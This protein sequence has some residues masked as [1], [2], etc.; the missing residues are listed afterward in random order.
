MRH[1]IDQGWPITPGLPSSPAWR[2]FP[3]NCRS[4]ARLAVRFTLDA[5]FTPHRFRL[6]LRRLRKHV[7]L[8]LLSSLHGLRGHATRLAYAWRAAQRLSPPSSTSPGAL[9]SDETDRPSRHAQY[10]PAPYKKRRR[11]PVLRLPLHG[12]L[13]LRIRL[14]R[15]FAP[16]EDSAPLPARRRHRRET[17]YLHTGRLGVSKAAP[18]PQLLQG[19][20]ITVPHRRRY[21]NHG[22]GASLPTF[23]A[24][25][26]LLRAP[27]CCECSPRPP[28]PP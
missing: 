16:A 24:P 17:C 12:G 2:R 7:L 9:R 19:S 28:E 20:P 21:P 27:N 14:S 11:Y 15:R 1:S 25:I 4:E 23:S 22:G 3:H 13:P 18:P 5:L 26:L 6:P 8:R 10:R